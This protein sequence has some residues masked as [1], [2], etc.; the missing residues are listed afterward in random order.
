MTMAE[1]WLRRAQALEGARKQ[2]T[3]DHVKRVR[4]QL[5]LLVEASVCSRQ[6]LHWFGSD[7]APGGR[8]HAAFKYGDIR[9]GNYPALKLTGLKHLRPEAVLTVSFVL[10]KRTSALVNY[11]VGL[12]GST[13]GSGRPWY[14]RIDLDETQKGEGPCSHP[15]LHCHIGNDP[16]SDD[17]PTARVPLPWLAPDEAL[18]WLMATA[19]PR[20]EPHKS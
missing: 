18:I 14:A 9:V 10:E 5:R 11:S 17:D 13:A 2:D 12:R 19:D 15:N 20:F 1:V 4:L 3:G 6:A 16:D 7:T 8:T